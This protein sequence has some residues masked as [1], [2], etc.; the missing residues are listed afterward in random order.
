MAFKT[1]VFYDIENLIKG[2]GLS[3]QTISTLSLTDIS[4]LIKEAYPLEGLAVQKAYANWSDP[5]LSVLR[6]QINDLG[7]DPIQVFGFSRDAK[8]N[9]ADIQLAIDAIDLA[10]TRPMIETYV[11]ISGDGGFAALAKK[12]HEY[13]KN[14]VGCAYKSTTNPSFKA[15]CDRFVYIQEPEWGDDADSHH[16]QQGFSAKS[17]HVSDPRNVRLSHKIKPLLANASPEQVLIK[18]RDV[19]GWYQEDA[20]SRS[21]LVS[22]GVVLSAVQEAI[23]YSVPDFQ[24]GRFGFSKFVEYMQ[25]ACADTPFCI[26]KP[27]GTGAVLARRDRV[28]ARWELLPDLKKREMHS[29]ENYLSIL[30]AGTPVFRLPTPSVL[31]IVANWL[32]GHA[33]PKQNFAELVLQAQAELTQHHADQV[34]YGLLCFLAA[35]AFVREPIHVT[36]A[37]QTV[38]LRP[39]LSHAQFLLEQLHLSVEA[40]LRSNVAEPRTDILHRLLHE[41]MLM[42][43]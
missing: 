15:V 29:L 9:A 43:D 22:T 33:K 18:V 13:G 31:P 6:H 41:P 5:R 16:P 39:D 8:K 4:R 20:I 26:A 42:A 27:E 25:Y 21:D 37:E 7:I 35:D 10:H 12:L 1:A 38:R 2:Y 32:V 14:V 17:A 24:L 11:I 3:Q 34:R 28:N 30:T 19:F 23:K 36:L 40:K